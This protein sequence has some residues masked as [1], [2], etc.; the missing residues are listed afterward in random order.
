MD[1]LLF[2]TAIRDQ[3]MPLTL[4]KALSG[5]RMGIFTGMERWNLIS[6][7]RVQVLTDTYLAEL[8]DPLELRDFLMIDSSVIVTEALVESLLSLD[9]GEGLFDNNGLIGGRVL[10]GALPEF[11]DDFSSLFSQKRSFELVKRIDLPC[12]VF[13]W[14]AEVLEFDFRLVTKGR[15]SAGGYDSVQMS[16]PSNIFIEEGAV[17]DFCILNASHGPIYVGKGATIMEGSTIRGPFAL[18]DTA[19]VKMGTKIYG[20]T[21]IG[22][23]CVAGGEIKNAIMMGYTNK[24]HDGYLG[25]SAIGEWCNLGAGTSN[26]NVKNTAGEVKLW[27]YHQRAFVSA[28]N[29]GGL[30]MGDYSRTA[31]NTSIN[32]GTVA[33]VC[34][35]IFGEGLTPKI[36]P[37]FTWGTKELSRYEFDKALKDIS[38][39]KQMK[40]K[41]FSES[42]ISILKYV[43]DNYND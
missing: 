34:C 25:D 13:Q 37:N 15:A 16:N 29:K 23:G 17:L 43:F 6:G 42:E 12:H 28:G 3:L 1:I 30:V 35:N 14:N 36:I 5:I 21:T 19:T 7:T 24:A 31:I 26:S 8:Y 33:G 38:K 2:D 4:T 18:C 22:P 9:N 32:T 20:A 41:L 27:N 11:G 10:P 39:W 40:N